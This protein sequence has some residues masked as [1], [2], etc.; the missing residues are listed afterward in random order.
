MDNDLQDLVTIDDY[1]VV[2]TSLK[3]AEIFEKEHYNVLR[4][5]KN[6]GCSADF[7]DLNFERCSY[8]VIGEKNSV[9][10]ED[11]YLITR[12]GFALL[13][14]CYTGEKAMRFKEAFMSQFGELEKQLI[15]SRHIEHME[16]KDGKP[17]R[18]NRVVLKSY[19]EVV[20]KMSRETN[21]D[22]LLSHWYGYERL[23]RLYG[24]PI[25]IKKP[26]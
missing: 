26:I 3:V 5:I 4:D 24:L 12:D 17:T 22:Y 16:S 8:Q 19:H 11:M 9:Q 13:A 6:L 10:D 15:I 18:L 7:T 1:R 21:P 20:E 25:A 14:M 23:C 2:T